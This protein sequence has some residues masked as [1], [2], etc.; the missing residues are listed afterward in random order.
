MALDERVLAV[1]DAMYDAAV[2]DARWPEALEQLTDVTGSQG[3]SFWVLDASA[4]PRLPTFTAINF[5]PTF[6]GE[7]LDEM[8][9]FDPTVQYL[10][11]HPDEAIVH[12]GLV[13]TEREKVRH[14]YYDWQRRHSDTDIWFRLV[15]QAC[16]AH[17]VQAGV[18]LHRT[19]KT[20][21]Y[22]VSDLDRFAVLQGHLQ[23]ALSIGFRLGALGTMQACTT[24]LLDRNPAAVL[25]LDAQ[26]R[27]VYANRRAASIHADDDGVRIDA[28]GVM[29][30]S[31][32][33]NQRL[34]RL[35]AQALSPTSAVAPGGTMRAARPS[36]N[37][38]YAVFV[39]PMPTRT[40]ALSAL[41]PAV[42]LVITD[43]DLRRPLEAQRLQEA[44]RF[45]EAEAKLAALLATGESLQSA[46]TTLGITYG[47][48]R[49]RLAELFQKTE[50]CRQGELISLLLTT[51]VA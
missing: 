7:Y 19:R 27:I 16:P 29:L 15:G 39:S 25:L 50:T 37:R 24:E 38:P 14:A 4:Q 46:A 21:P 13:I 47:T 9:P 2:D 51:V 31:K 28:N 48:A 18:A 41:R 8:V 6:I 30:R 26:K 11:A 35:V 49:V 23:R 12:D 45:T 43:P 20:G 5:D 1:I 42:C 17:L 34:Q 44:F 3:A 22:E 10:V 32:A 36:G 40:P 33:D